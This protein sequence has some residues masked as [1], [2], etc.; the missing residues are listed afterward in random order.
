[1]LLLAAQAAAELVDLQLDQL[2]VLLTQAVAAAE[3]VLEL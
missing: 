3:K 2:Q 1:M